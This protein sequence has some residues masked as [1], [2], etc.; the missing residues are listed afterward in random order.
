MATSLNNSQPARDMGYRVV[1]YI[2]KTIA[3]NTPGVATADTVKVGTIPSGTTLLGCLVN[4][5]TA[6]NAAT[7][8]VIIVGNASDD[9]A[10][11]AAGD[12]TEGSTG[13]TLV[14]RAMGNKPSSDTTI[15]V[16]YDQTGTAATAGAADIIIFYTPVIG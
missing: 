3:Y 6:F 8:N 5:T 11:V 12:V 7:T 13:A 10:Y 14:T 16:Q 9:D 2:S 4:I 1:N 15:Y